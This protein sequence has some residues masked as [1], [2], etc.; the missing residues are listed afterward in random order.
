MSRP[1][2]TT[3]T[4]PSRTGA[5]PSRMSKHLARAFSLVPNIRMALAL[6]EGKEDEDTSR[7]P[8]IQRAKRDKP[9]HRRV[10]KW[11]KCGREF[12]T[13]NGR[14]NYCTEQCLNARC[15][16]KY[17][18]QKAVQKARYADARMEDNKAWLDYYTREMMG[19]KA[20]NGLPPIPPK[21]RGRPTRQKKLAIQEY[22]QKLARH[23][24]R[25]EI[26]DLQI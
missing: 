13:Q 4:T 3:A 8:P 24:I 12:T 9:T 6:I 19:Y 7:L 16:W 14:Q 2:S 15:Q 25:R 23:K 20:D 22:R 17:A 5:T 1:H 11:H 10:C 18:R 26:K 21:L